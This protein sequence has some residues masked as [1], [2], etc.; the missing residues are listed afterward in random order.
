MKRFFTLLALAWLAAGSAVAQTSDEQYVHIYDLIQEA[1]TLCEKG[2]LKDALPKYTEALTLLQRFQKGYPL[3][4]Q[5]VVKF[6][7]EYLASKTA[8][9]S[10]KVPSP[11]SPPKT[12]T[13]PAPAPVKPAPADWE[14]QVETLKAQVRQLQSDKGLLESKLKEALS[15]QPAAVDPREVAKAEEKVRALQKENEL[16]NTSLQQEK[17]KSAQAAATR[18]DPRTEEETAALKTETARQ[19]EEISRLT[20][21]R[22]ALQNRLK[23]AAPAPVT[24]APAAPLPAGADTNLVAT[25]RARIETL[26]AQ[27]VPFSAEE[28]ALIE[29]NRPVTGTVAPPRKA[30]GKVSRS[31]AALLAEAQ[32]FIAAKQ[33]DK[34]EERC[35]RALKEDEQNVAL[36]GNLAEIQVLLNHLDDAEKHVLKAVSL[37]PEDAPTLSTLGHLRTRQ[38]KIDEAVDALSRAAKLDPQNA[39]I[40][41]RLGVALSE[42]GLRAPAETALR[43]A[44]QLQPSFADAHKNLAVA[45]LSQEPPLTELARWHYQKALAAGSPPLPDLEKMLE[46]KKTAAAPK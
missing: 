31:A 24:P 1:D 28:L 43:K 14:N 25:L 41:N 6:R 8:E 3:W 40:Q 16:L 20:V 27:P 44:I 5:D 37:A 10:A 2:L 45:Y 35:L 33:F 21:E 26:E 4:N 22:D 23:S 9:L 19:K 38:H 17:A 46:A 42:K 13:V 15:A 18:K 36:L 7:L 12:T 29:K 11:I 32:K 30:S 39:D 34:A